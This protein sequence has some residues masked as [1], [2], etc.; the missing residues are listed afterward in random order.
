MT[1]IDKKIVIFYPD[2]YSADFEKYR[3]I[4]YSLERHR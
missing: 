2:D 1:D 4:F 3:Y